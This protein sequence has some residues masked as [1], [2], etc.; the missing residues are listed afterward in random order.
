MCRIISKKITSK[1]GI[2]KKNLDI[3]FRKLF[4]LTNGR[5]GKDNNP[6][7]TAKL[8]FRKLCYSNFCFTLRLH[9]GHVQFG[10]NELD[11]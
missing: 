2:E 9:A 7:Q 5:N 3:V 11:T 10:H 4:F 8:C 6:N 1:K